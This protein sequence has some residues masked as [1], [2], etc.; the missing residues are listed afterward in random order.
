MVDIKLTCVPLRS[1]EQT[2]GGLVTLERLE[3]PM[4][5][6][7][8]F[9]TDGVFTYI[10]P[11]VTPL[12]GYLPEEVIGKPSAAFN[13]PDEIMQ[14]VEFR[15]LSYIERDSV[16]FIGRVRH[17][18]GEYRLYE[19]TSEYVRDES[20]EIVQTICIGRDITG[21]RQAEGR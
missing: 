10:S 2:I 4:H 5:I 16:R 8:V 21:L 19:T 15:G 17:K 11:T 20:G 13:H 18:N 14:L 12:L 7:S 6:I 9:S 1:G 3:R